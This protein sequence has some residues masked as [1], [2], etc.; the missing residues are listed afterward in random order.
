MSST[1]KLHRKFYCLIS[2]TQ[3][4]SEFQHT[5]LTCNF[6][7][8][9]NRDR[10]FVDRVKRNAATYVKIFQEVIDAHM[11][12]PSLNFRDEDLTSFDVIMEQRRFNLQ[13]ASQLKLQQ[14]IITREGAGTDANPVC[15]IPAELE[16]NYQCVLI[17][18]QHAKKHIMEMRNVKADNIGSLVTVRG[19]V[20]RASDVK[21][22][23]QVAVY[24]C[25]ACGFE[26]YQ[27][28]NSKEF[29]PVVQCPSDKCKTNKVNGQLLFQVKSSRF[30]SYQDIKIQEPSDQ[31][32]IGHV[33]RMIK[34]VAKG[35]I[36]RRCSPGDMVSVTGIFMP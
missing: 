7:N 13:M 32:P 33:P 9:T 35:E 21:P 14:G 12:K 4:I 5:N 2:L 24:A 18:G 22:C 36:T 3:N 16:R 27:L 6:S 30:V 28:I 19:I 1:S 34:I 23:M 11:P 10:G 15:R 20:T 26:V 31:V 17:H 8:S 25:D 29:N